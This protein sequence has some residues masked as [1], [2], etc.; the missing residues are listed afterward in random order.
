MDI[1][2][3][4]ALLI[5][6]VLI[7]LSAPTQ[8]QAFP[9]KPVRI[10]T[11]D[12]AG[13]AADSLLRLL[14]ER[15]SPR[16]GQPVI[17][18][19]RPGADGMIAMDLCAKAP[20]DGHTLCLTAIALMSITPQ[21]R[22][23][24][25][26]PLEDVAPVTPLVRVGGV[27]FVNPSLQATSTRDLLELARSK[28][29]SLTYASFGNGSAAHM[30]FEWLKRESGVDMLHVPYQ[31]G[32]PALLSVVSGTNHTGYFALAGAVPQIRGGKIR[33]LA[34]HALVRSPLLPD[35]PTMREAGFDYPLY[36]WFGMVTPR[37]VSE[38]LRTRIASEYSQII[39]DP[40]IYSAIENMGFQPYTSN[41]KDFAQFLR[42]DR[43]N[44]A[45]LIK[46]VQI[47]PD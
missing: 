2:N 26:D 16:L 21:I 30:L 5:C 17:V 41:P 15:L 29:G 35:V 9:V 47:K 24:T 19:N 33:A 13:G 20:S 27:I 1:R 11:S 6:C 40:S 8:G 22:K 45:R 23:V 39:S 10:I 25:F 38:S 34:V 3:I 42:T 4:S 43:E 36:S 44:A 28:P 7:G 46:L 37:Q 31:G 32:P 18:E 12:V 14:N